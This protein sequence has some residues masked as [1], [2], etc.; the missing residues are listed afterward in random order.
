MRLDDADQVK[1]NWR[2]ESFSSAL[3]NSATQKSVNYFAIYST[4][5]Q[6]HRRRQKIDNAGSRMAGMESSVVIVLSSSAP[7]PVN[8]PDAINGDTA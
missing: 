7:P 6:P 2:G 3:E 4:Q 5:P 8:E 1:I